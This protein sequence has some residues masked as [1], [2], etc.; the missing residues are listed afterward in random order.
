MT[1]MSKFLIMQLFQDTLREKNLESEKDKK[2][3]EKRAKDVK[4]KQR[5]T[6]YS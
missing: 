3:K 5:S 4:K 2:E 6:S 1:N